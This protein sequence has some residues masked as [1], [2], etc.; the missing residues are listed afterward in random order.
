MQ[1]YTK[2][3][4]L[5]STKFCFHNI[6]SILFVYCPVKKIYILYEGLLE[7]GK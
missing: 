4:A 5:L 7:G 6:I 1:K 3:S 2:S